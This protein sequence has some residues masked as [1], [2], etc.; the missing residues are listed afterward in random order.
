MT[1]V[2]TNNQSI[3][4][5]GPITKWGVVSRGFCIFGGVMAIFGGIALAGLKARGDDSMI[6]AIANGM[7]Y[8][9]IGKGIFMIAI[10]LNFRE[11]LQLFRNR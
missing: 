4:S 8:Y 5:E 1:E 9:F 2:A 10:T 7:G 6:E 3:S 11:A